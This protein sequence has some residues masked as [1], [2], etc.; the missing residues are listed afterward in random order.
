M[1]ILITD[2]TIISTNLNKNILDLYK[3]YVVIENNFT[4]G[5]LLKYKQVIFFNV[6]SSLTETEI[7]KLFKF[8]KDNNILYINVTNDIEELLY[9]DKLIIYD[10]EKVLVEGNTIELLKN[11]KLLKRLG[12]NLP[13][14]VQISILLKDY[15]LIDKIYFDKESLVGELWK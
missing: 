1:I 3:D 11:E 15:N 7:K 9:T 14:I 2:V 6:L 12:F 5:E 8:L 4:Y 10:K 13:F